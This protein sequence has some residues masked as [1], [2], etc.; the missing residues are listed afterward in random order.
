MKLARPRRRGQGLRGASL[1]PDKE[2]RKECQYNSDFQCGVL[3][4]IRLLR[5]SLFRILER[6]AP[7]P[8]SDPG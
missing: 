5:E 8:W 2:G 6:Y 4:R 3:D 7:Y 1:P